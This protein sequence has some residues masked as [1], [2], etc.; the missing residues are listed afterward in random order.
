MTASALL[1][2]L[3]EDAANDVPNKSA[4][5]LG[6]CG[7]TYRALNR[8][9]NRVAH[10]VADVGVEPGDTVLV[11]LPNCLEYVSVLFGLAKAGAVGAL[12]DTEYR[13]DG[14]RHLVRFSDA[15][16]VVV[17]DGLLDPVLGA[18]E[19]VDDD[20]AELVTVASGDGGNPS[21][22]AWMTHHGSLAALTDGRSAEQPAAAGEVDPSDPL[23]LVHTSGTT[24][25]PKWCRL[26]HAA[27]VH[28]TRFWAETMGIRADDR[29]FNPLPLYHL[30]PL[31]LALY[32]AISARATAILAEE[33]YASRFWSQVTAADVSVIVVIFSVVDILTNRDEASP[34]HD[35]RVMFPPDRDFLDRFEI[36]EAAGLYGSTETA[37]AIA[38]RRFSRP[39]PETEE[40]LS[41]LAG[42]PRPDLDVAIVDEGDERVPA[43]EVGE[44]VVRP[45]KPDRLFDQYHNA[46]EQ[47]VAAWR[48]LWYH[49]GDLGY[50]DTDGELHFV[51]RKAESIRVRG[52]F[53][54]IDLVEEAIESQDGVRECVVVG[55]P[56][57][58]GD[59]A[60]AAY[61]KPVEGTTLD[62]GTLRATAAESVPDYML[63]RYVAFVDEYPRTGTQK[64]QTERLAER[65]LS[66]AWDACG[67]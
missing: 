43:G 1:H 40:A 57:D 32:P 12:V 60:V 45:E 67:R 11:V 6:E 21:V 16:V 8:R 7:Y 22:P 36:P 28:Q 50:L 4:V 30:N 33:F 3:L 24:G 2:H 56:A 13:G 42:P 34:E 62:P 35:V 19:A 48:N 65:D 5:E 47:T 29:V 18:I 38:G 9:A 14:L 66:P 54:N 31:A 58:I 61:V 59:E 23:C 44:I 10:A 49:S 55:V 52:N 17:G 26:S 46:P 53:V 64:I 41:Q 15:D 51:Q 20:Q 37:G 25:L 27:I 39:F 63:P